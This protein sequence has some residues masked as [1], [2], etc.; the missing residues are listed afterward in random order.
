[1]SNAGSVLLAALVLISASALPSIAQS[2]D[3]D[4]T[5]RRMDVAMYPESYFSVITMATV[6]P[7]GES[8]SMTFEVSYKH[9]VGSRMEITA[10]AR[11]RGIRFLQKDNFLWLFNPRS[12]SRRAIRLSARDSFQGSAFSNS[13]VSETEFSGRYHAAVLRHEPIDVDGSSRSCTVIEANA[14]DR[15][16]PY[17]KVVLWI[18]AQSFVPYRMDYYAR[19]GLLFKRMTLSRIREIAGR[20]RPTFYRMESFDQPGLHSDVSIDTLEARDDLPDRLF[21]EADLTQ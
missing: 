16:S 5:I 12:G 7:S 9:G 13:D 19:S 18:D 14:K 1:M 3:A 11:S 20:E 6:Q 2:A 17:A 4:Q 10:P 8:T 15:S 21:T